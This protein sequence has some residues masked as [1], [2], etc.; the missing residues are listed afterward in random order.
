MPDNSTSRDKRETGDTGDRHSNR[1][2]W[3]WE[4]RRLPDGTLALDAIARGS[5]QKRALE[6]E[7]ARPRA[8]RPHVAGPAVDPYWTP[9]GPSVVANGQAAGRPFVSGRITSLA[10]GA[11]GNR[12]YAGAANGGVWYSEDSG[13]S[14]T[15]IDLYALTG[16]PAK[17][18]H[19]EADSLATGD[20]QVEVGKE[21]ALPVGLAD[22]A[23]LA[24]HLPATAL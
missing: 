17:L 6:A 23:R 15:P 10:V 11:G 19:M 4:R 9:L 13:S 14:W 22:T 21:R 24:D 20:M 16:Q 1:H 2:D 12:V 7:V 5:R 8:F 18:A 3:F